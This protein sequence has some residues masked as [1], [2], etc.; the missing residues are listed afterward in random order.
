MQVMAN[1]K[2]SLARIM[3]K[4]PDIEAWLASPGMH[5]GEQ[6]AEARSTTASDIF[7]PR[8]ESLL[9]KKQPAAANKKQKMSAEINLNSPSSSAT[10]SPV[11]LTE[12][13]GQA[14]AAT[15][16]TPLLL[17]KKYISMPVVYAHVRLH[18]DDLMPGSLPDIDVADSSPLMKS[19]A[20]RICTPGPLPKARKSKKI[21]AFHSP[22]TPGTP[23]TNTFHSFE[24][25]IKQMED[26]EMYL[27]NELGFP[28]ACF[29][30]HGWENVDPVLIERCASNCSAISES[31]PSAEK[32]EAPAPAPGV[33]KA[34]APSN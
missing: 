21:F 28:M 16:I 3:A 32:A 7:S 18:A 15:T 17:N 33:A 4:S 20:N 11:Y 25:E 23:V 24:D 14:L 22:S 13:P 5:R 1:M 9:R 30:E 10:A 12:E 27:I 6:A 34:A 26:M 2:L 31:A 8:M 19:V 29:Y